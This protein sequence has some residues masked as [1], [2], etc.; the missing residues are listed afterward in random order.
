MAL[1]GLPFMAKFRLNC[2]FDDNGG[3]SIHVGDPYNPSLILPTRTLPYV[4]T[5]E[6]HLALNEDLDIGPGETLEISCHLR[7][8]DK[9]AT[10]LPKSAD[11]QLLPAW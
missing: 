9:S 1:C 8:S 4:A 3:V 6:D 5:P 2:I 11:C 7:T 10:G